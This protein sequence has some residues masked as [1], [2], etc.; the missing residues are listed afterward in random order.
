VSAP[1]FVVALKPVAV[2]REQAAAMLGLSLD[3]FERYVQPELKLIRRGSLRL[4]PVAE[5]ERWA[6]ENAEPL[7]TTTNNHH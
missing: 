2:K 5:L 7:F 4:C 3:S 6:S 1:S